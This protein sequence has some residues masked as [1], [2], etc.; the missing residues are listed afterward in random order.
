[1]KDLC[2]QCF[3]SC[4]GS[5]FLS[6]AS[7]VAAISVVDYCRIVALAMFSVVYIV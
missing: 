2:V 5:V 4:V 7:L 1:M 3:I 6:V